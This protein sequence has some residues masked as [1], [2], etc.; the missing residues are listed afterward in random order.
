MATR[1]AT[2]RSRE[3]ARAR[4]R[5]ARLAH[6]IRRMSAVIANRNCRASS[7]WVRSALTPVAAG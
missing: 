2:S 3:L 6:E 1:T 5:L 4:S 7:Y